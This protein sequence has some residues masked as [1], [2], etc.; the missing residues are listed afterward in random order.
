VRKRA[1]IIAVQ[2]Y[3][4]ARLAELP[5]AAADAEQLAAVL[6]DPLIGGF[7]V[8]ALIDERGA[9]TGQR[10][11]GF[12]RSAERDDLL[13]LHLSC[14]GQKDL[15][16]RL[17]FAAADTDL[18]YPASSS[19]TSGFINDL[20]E[21]TRAKRVVLMLDC[22][23][24]GA[25]SKGLRTRAGTPRIDVAEPFSGRGRVVITSS[26]SLQYSYEGELHSR[27]EADPALFTAAVVRGL[28]DGEADLDGDGHISVAELYDFVHDQVSRLR[29][30]QTPTMTVNSA[31]GHIYLARSPRTSPQ[32]APSVPAVSAAIAATIRSREFAAI[33][34]DRT[35]DFVGRAFVFETV[36]GFLDAADFPCGYVVI[37]GE[38]GI[39]KTSLLAELVRRHGHV[40]HFNIASQN[41]RSAHDFLAN[42]C[43][44]LIAKY[45]LPYTALAP[46]ATTGSGFLSRLL[47]EA[48]ERA[49]GGRVVVLVD[50]LDEADDTGLPLDANRLF[51]PAT[52]PA[53][54]YIVATSRE[55]HDY[56]LTVDALE[57]IALGDEDPRNRQDILRYILD[58]VSDNSATMSGRL[59][60]WDVSVKAFAK[61]LTTKS[62]GNFM[63]LVTVLRDIRSGRLAAGSIGSIN[64][65]PNGLH[66]YYQRHWRT[67]R[68]EDPRRF[69]EL[70][71]PVI[72]VL[73]VT[74]E[75]VSVTDLSEWTRLTAS[76]VRGVL[77]EWREFLNE[78]HDGEGAVKYRLY[79]ASFQDFLR[80][81]VAL[82]DYHDTIADAGMRKIFEV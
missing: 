41:I 60:D 23:Y 66:A 78:E 70:Y 16:G 13:V 24:S 51:L 75:P 20:M 54:A 15:R 81:E 2:R 71:E 34:A 52:L 79:H 9:T 45:G 53:G 21:E 36:D 29:P 26:T 32:P 14:H 64:R 47:V 73:A 17:F 7:E 31:E 43:A 28:R 42:I 57:E 55:L 10:I 11:E 33:V 63:Y 48:V 69:Q 82:Q 49:P 37:R 61:M 19:I 56:R 50:A 4:D 62:Q 38:P 72:C 35:R 59:A 1:L 6:G 80:E 58:F 18:G 68:S 8:E 22:C 40:H 5:S 46:E 12:F 76:Q 3:R 65:L 67:M 77:R 30:D 27:R 25:F 74:R 39:G 44:Q